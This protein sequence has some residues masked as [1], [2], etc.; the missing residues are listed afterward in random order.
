MAGESWTP[1]AVPS[2]S[3]SG[4]AGRTSAACRGEAADALEEG[5]LC[6]GPDTVAAF[7]AEP[8]VG[9]AAGAVVPPPGYWP[10]VVDI[11]RKYGVLLI[12]DE[13]MCGFGRTGA[14]FA[15]NH[16]GVTPDIMVGG[17]G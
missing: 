16:W 10:R 11:C 8:V 7:I 2:L 1:P 9:G 4:T 3:T 15:V 5:I 14:K 6:E 13:V 12:A 17:K